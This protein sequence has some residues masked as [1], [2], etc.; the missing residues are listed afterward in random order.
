MKQSALAIL[1][2][3]LLLLVGGGVFVL[4]GGA[5]PAIAVSRAA[6]PISIRQPLTVTVKEQGPGLKDLTVTAIQ[7]ER[8]VTLAS[9]RF[10]PKLHRAE[11][12]VSLA[13][14]GLKE[15]PWQLQVVA[16]DRSWAHFGAGNSSSRVVN[17]RFDNKPP[18]IAVLS[19]AHNIARGGVGLAVYSV[20]KEVER[21]GVAFDT[22]F[23]PG[24]RQKNGN[25]A[26][27]FPFPYDLP[28]ERYVPKVMALDPAGNERRAGIYFHLIAKRFS[29]DRITL[30]DSFLEKVAAEFK[31]KYPQ[32]DNPLEIF[33]KVNREERQLDLKT[34]KELG[35][36]SSPV[37]LWQDEFLRLPNSAPKGGYAQARTYL[38]RGKV[39]DQQT[40]LGVD[41]ASL[42]H[43]PVPAA[44]RGTVVFAD[45]LG[46]YGQCVVV[47]HGLGLQS[48]YGH[49][50]QISAKVGDQVE[51]GT[52]IGRTGDT[53]LAGGDHL[54]FG[55]V[56]SGEQV[57]PIE[58]WDPSWLKNNITDKLQ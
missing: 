37:P 24:Y 19:I 11:E 17:Y 47:D 49:L 43:A 10:P 1:I 39:V 6:G 29:A 57:N 53:G 46:I 7:G 26:S 23:F 28:D 48:L 58:W 9:K 40:H 55:M 42:P 15:G 27:L 51:K 25:Y 35:L 8:K 30:T 38:Y 4:V 21:T 50:S 56:V 2:V 13:N 33:L 20:N 16:R 54:H 3:L 31:D 41:L 12:P 18:A 14:A 22:R 45:Y 44:N 52:I 36:K 32:I 5:G 34:L